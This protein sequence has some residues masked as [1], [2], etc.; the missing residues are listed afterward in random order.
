M[1][2]LHPSTGASAQLPFRLSSQTQCLSKGDEAEPWIARCMLF[3]QM[4][5]TNMAM[6][7]IYAMLS[8]THLLEHCMN[9]IKRLSTSTS[10]FGWTIGFAYICK[11]MLDLFL[12]VGSIRTQSVISFSWLTKNPVSGKMVAIQ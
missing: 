8:E 1:F 6:P 11:A 12:S 4:K 10:R 9:A 3:L 7:Q 2:C 5:L